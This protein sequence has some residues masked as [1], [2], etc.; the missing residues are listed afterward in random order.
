M[1]NTAFVRYP[2]K[3]KESAGEPNPIKEISAHKVPDYLK[4]GF[5]Q[6]TADGKAVAKTGGGSD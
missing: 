5:V 2:D 4:R 1:A 6:V 3:T